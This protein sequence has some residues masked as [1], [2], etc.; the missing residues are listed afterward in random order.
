MISMEYFVRRNIHRP[1]LCAKQII[2][3][4]R[5]YILFSFHQRLLS[6]TLYKRS[7]DANAVGV[8]DLVEVSVREEACYRCSTSKIRPAVYILCAL[9]F[10]ECCTNAHLLNHIGGWTDGQSNL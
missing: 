1:C 9:F 8:T 2:S 4:F 5:L 10:L 3:Y 6:V 7:C